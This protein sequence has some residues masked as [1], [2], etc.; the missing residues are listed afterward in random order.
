MATNS[1]SRPESIGALEQDSDV[2]VGR[3]QLAADLD[4]KTGKER[5]HLYLDTDDVEAEVKRLEALGATRWGHQT[6]RGFDFW[7]IRDSWEN[8]FSV[9][10]ATF[11]GLLARRRSWNA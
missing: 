11:P 6:G 8:E 4:P 2:C 1:S 9:L 10:Q 5:T 3:P 7:V